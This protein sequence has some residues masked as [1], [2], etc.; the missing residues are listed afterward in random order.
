MPEPKVP[1]LETLKKVYAIYMT[2]EC[3]EKASRAY[4]MSRHT[5]D[6]YLRRNGFDMEAP[7]PKKP[8]V[9]KGR[10]NPIKKW[11][12]GASKAALSRPLIGRQS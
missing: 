9:R 3:L 7:R 4:K 12:Y 6:K 11:A 8:R 2:G 10:P 1:T 5:A